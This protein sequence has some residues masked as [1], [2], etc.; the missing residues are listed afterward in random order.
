MRKPYE[1]TV[2]RQHNIMVILTSYNKSEFGAH[3]I[4]LNQFTEVPTKSIIPINL[5]YQLK[6]SK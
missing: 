2:Q 5:P 4:S 3:K 6:L 1:M